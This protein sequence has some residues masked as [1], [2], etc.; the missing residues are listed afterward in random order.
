M[1]C[2]YIP[3][4]INEQYIMLWKRDEA[5]FLM[6]PWLFVFILGGWIGFSLTLISTIVVARLLKMLSLDKPSGY[7]LHWFRFHLP[8]QFIASIFSNKSKLEAPD[9]LIFRGGALPPT[10][11]RYIAG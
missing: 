9:S 4:E 7:L 3:R 6:L 1:K 8:K 5:L 2:L 11:I 10:H